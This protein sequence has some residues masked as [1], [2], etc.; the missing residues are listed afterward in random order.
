MPIFN[1]I[2]GGGGGDDSLGF[3]VVAQADQPSSPTENMIWVETAVPMPR[4]VFAAVEPQNPETGDVWI[5]T[6]V[7]S[8]VEFNAADDSVNALMVYPISAKQFSGGAWEAVSA[9]SYIDGAWMDW[10]NG[11]FY[12]PGNMFEGLTGGWKPVSQSGLSATIDATGIVFSIT[13][14][15][16]RHATV[17]TENKIDVS[18]YSTMI[19]EV[20]LTEVNNKFTF[21]LTTANTSA[22]ASFAYSTVQSTVTDGTVEL[23]LDISSA[24]DEYYLGLY[25]YASVGLVTKVALR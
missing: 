25:S 22:Q 5:S 18:D 1:M 3:S 8:A 2:Y 9:K 6:G 19:V 12:L 24:S 23:L 13:G 10:W 4:W 21:G 20:N 17:F 15:T 11:E 7:S 16:Y 14:T